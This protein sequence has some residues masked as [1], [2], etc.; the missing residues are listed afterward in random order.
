MSAAS[1]RIRRLSGRELGGHLNRCPELGSRPALARARPSLGG[2]VCCDS[3]EPDGPLELMREFAGAACESPRALARS[4]LAGPARA[5]PA[6]PSRVASLPPPPKR[7]PWG[8]SQAGE[9]RARAGAKSARRPQN[10]ISH[11][12]WAGTSALECAQCAPIQIQAARG[13]P[14]VWLACWLNLVGNLSNVSEASHSNAANPH[15]PKPELVG[16]S[17]RFHCTCFRGIASKP[18]WQEEAAA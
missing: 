8:R 5:N 1:K 11:S 3:S 7:R 6:Q 13:D 16:L 4:I 9:S 14:S 17:G 15:R 12:G 2:S 18:R 10:A